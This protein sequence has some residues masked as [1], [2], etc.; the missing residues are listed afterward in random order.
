MT[1]PLNGSSADGP[2]DQDL[3][4][5]LRFT[6]PR[7]FVD[8]T[9]SAL[10][11]P[12]VH[13]AWRDA[14]RRRR[15]RVRIWRTAVAA[16]VVLAMAAVWRSHITP[17]SPAAV[18]VVVAG[19][20]PVTM[21]PSGWVKVASVSVLGMGDAIPAGAAVMTD[22]T[23]RATLALPSQQGQLRLD[24]DT[25]AQVGG[26]GVITVERGRVYLDSGA[27]R[28]VRRGFEVRTVHGIVHDVGTRFEVHVTDA[29][30]RV[31]VRDGAV[32]VTRGATTREA[33]AGT[34]LT[35]RKSVV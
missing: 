21:I 1:T 12:V 23:S 13:R 30:L 19:S 26:D 27:R 7:P 14:A 6:A 5:L 16:L 9:W 11:R 35:D 17:G 32:T 20:G 15:W 25:R 3:V 4:R 8:P 18:V 2:D 28:T 31:R 29:A 22:A 24:V 33:K 34:E 10:A